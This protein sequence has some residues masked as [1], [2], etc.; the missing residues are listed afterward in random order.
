MADRVSPGLRTDAAS[1]GGTNYRTPRDLAPDDDGNIT[2]FLPGT[3]QKYTRDPRT[4]LVPGGGIKVGPSPA[5]RGLP[6]FREA[7]EVTRMI[8]DKA[9]KANATPR[10]TDTPLPPMADF[11]PPQAGKSG[12]LRPPVMPIEREDSPA[13]IEDTDEGKL[14]RESIGQLN[15]VAWAS[16]KSPNVHK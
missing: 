11:G 9:T 7:P 8:A 13:G 15:P 5:E 16:S 3:D 1:G 4:T 14:Y 10:Y 6:P 12:A 2:E